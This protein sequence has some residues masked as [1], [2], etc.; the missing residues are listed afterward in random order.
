MQLPT[1]HISTLIL[2]RNYAVNLV[3]WLF[4]YETIFDSYDNC[5]CCDT[6]TAVLMWRFDAEV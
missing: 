5:R 1:W 3:I 4:G 2:R 6:G